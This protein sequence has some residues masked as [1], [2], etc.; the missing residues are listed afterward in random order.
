MEIVTPVL[1]KQ[2]KNIFPDKNQ[3]KISIL[4]RTV[5]IKLEL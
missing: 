2:K 3:D 5:R 4:Q 1:W